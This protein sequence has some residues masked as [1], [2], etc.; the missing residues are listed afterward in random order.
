LA[1]SPRATLDNTALMWHCVTAQGVIAMLDLHLTPR[2]TTAPGD[3]GGPI[4]DVPAAPR[5][6]MDS[7]PKAHNAG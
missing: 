5:R 7:R 6:T 3:R 4:S 2:L 1:P